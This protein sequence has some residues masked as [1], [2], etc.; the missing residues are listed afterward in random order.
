MYSL[1]L[2]MALGNGASVPADT[3]SRNDAPPYANHGHV[4][5][6]GRGCNGTRPLGSRCLLQRTRTRATKR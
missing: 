1:V 4:A 2:M 3:V 5:Y 6:R